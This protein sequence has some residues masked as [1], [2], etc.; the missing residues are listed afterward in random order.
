MF[1]DTIIIIILTEISDKMWHKQ[2]SQI[3]NYSKSQWA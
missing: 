3:D 1:E 2:T